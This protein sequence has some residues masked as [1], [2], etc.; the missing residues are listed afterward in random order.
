[1]ILRQTHFYS[2][3]DLSNLREFLHQSLR[4]AFENGMSHSNGG[5]F[6][7]D[8]NKT[9]NLPNSERHFLTSECSH[10]VFE[11]FE[12]TVNNWLPCRPDKR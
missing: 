9:E 12:E 6:I 10:F 1:M 5:V 4:E 7:V 11:E 2:F 8:M 3:S